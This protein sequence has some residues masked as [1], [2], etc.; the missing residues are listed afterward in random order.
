M[1]Y[2]RNLNRA[3]DATHICKLPNLLVSGCSFTYN[4]SN[5]H[6]CSWPY[7]L[8]DLFDFDK[9]FDCSQSGAGSNHI[10]N[11]VINEIENDKY[12]TCENTLVVIAWSGLTRTDVI[13]S[14]EITKPWHH[15][16]NYDFNDKFSTLSI[17]NLTKGKTDL[18]N[19]CKMY[20]TYIDVEAQILESAF[21]IIALKNYLENKKMKHVFVQYQ[22]LTDEIN[23]LEP[24][25]KS[26]TL[27]CFDNIESIGSYSKEFESDGHPTPNGYLAWTKDCLIPHLLNKYSAFF[28]K[29]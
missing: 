4:N 18:D 22:D 20:K 14:S 15:M 1:S 6:V 9:V 28:Q 12:I 26:Q 21:K 24:L 29:L 19:L 16:S 2:K 25:V 7:Y 8:R 17:F 11:S 10:F 3:F 23:Y 13:A 27:K 5:E